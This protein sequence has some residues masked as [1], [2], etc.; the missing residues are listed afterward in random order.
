MSDTD[1]LKSRY[2]TEESGGKICLAP[3]WIAAVAVGR[4]MSAVLYVFERS[5]DDGTT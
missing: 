4:M 1:R 5:S 3:T 2:W